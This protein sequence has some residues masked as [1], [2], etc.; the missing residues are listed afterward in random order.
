MVMGNVPSRLRADLIEF[1]VARESQPGLVPVADE[2][3]QI[4]L[5]PNG[6]TLPDPQFEWEPFY[7]LGVDD[8]NFTH[9]IQG[10]HQFQGSIP[11]IYLTHTEGRFL[12]EMLM[13]VSYNAGGATTDVA[14]AY[15]RDTGIVTTSV[16]APNAPGVATHI[17]IAGEATATTAPWAYL[18]L[19]TPTGGT[20]ATYVYRDR[21]LTQFG[22][23]GKEPT[24]SGT[25]VVRSVQTTSVSATTPDTTSINYG[26]GGSRRVII[27]QSIVQPTFSVGAKFFTDTGERFNRIYTGNKIGRASISLEEGRPVTMNVDFMGTGM[28]HDLGGAPT[29]GTDARASIPRYQADGTI[30]DTTTAT[31]TRDFDFDPISSQPYFFSTAEVKFLG[32]TFARFRNLNIEINNQI[33]PLFYVHGDNDASVTDARQSPIEILEGRR[34]ITLRGSL[35]ADGTEL[36]GNPSNATFFEQ[37]LQQGRGRSTVGNSLVGLSVVITLATKN[38]DGGSTSDAIRIVL[39]GSLDTSDADNLNIQGTTGSGA[40]R[41]SRGANHVTDVGLIIRSANHNVPAPPAIHVPVDVEG[42]AASCRFEVYDRT[43]TTEI[44]IT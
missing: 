9:P 5:I 32:T 25:W 33:E 42:L 8:R 17:V 41:V 29:T 26:T 44:D 36:G 27:R 15:D 18:G 37:L 14:T 38:S 19:F 23:N 34:A 6:L 31:T 1:A 21:A 10:R 40:S 28:R 20:E 2:F 43:T 4:G 11:S 35:D 22:W 30:A 3:R 13:G 7:G 16:T 39:P 12:L 24:F